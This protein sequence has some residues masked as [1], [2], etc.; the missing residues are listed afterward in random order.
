MRDVVPYV[1]ACAVGRVFSVATKKNVLPQHMFPFPNLYMERFPSPVIA[2]WCAHAAG[3]TVH[4]RLATA[5]VVMSFFLRAALFFFFHHSAPCHR[6]YRKPIALFTTAVHT[7]I[8]SPQG[9]SLAH[10][11][12]Q[13]SHLFPD[14]LRFFFFFFKLMF[15]PATP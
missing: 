5:V 2:V 11:H 12:W 7:P 4:L 15:P 6:L 10:R 9:P 3:T 14:S 13:S 1:R 8:T